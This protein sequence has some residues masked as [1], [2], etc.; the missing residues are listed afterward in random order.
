MRACSRFLVYPTQP[1]AERLFPPGLPAGRRHRHSGESAGGDRRAGRTAHRSALQ[2]L[3]VDSLGSC[4]FARRVSRDDGRRSHP[5][6][7]WPPPA[8]VRSTPR[9]EQHAHLD[10]FRPDVDVD[11]AASDVREAVSRIER[12]LPDA[13]EQLSVFKADEQAEE[14]IRIACL[15]A[16]EK[17]LNQLNKI[18]CR[19]LSPCPAWRRAFWRT[20]ARAED[21]PRPAPINKLW[22]HRR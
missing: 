11:R 6:A 10:E 21:H 7:R 13:V 8:S 19:A 14:I 17:D 3:I 22:P 15:P 16:T 4:V 12:E 2:T 5:V 18:S 1:V 9:Q 20:A